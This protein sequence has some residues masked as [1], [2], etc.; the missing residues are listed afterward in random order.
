MNIYDT[1]SVVETYFQNLPTKEKIMALLVIPLLLGG[2]SFGYLTPQA[3]QLS[4]QS[5]LYA[6]Q[7]SLTHEKLTTQITLEKNQSPQSPLIDRYT[8]LQQEQITLTNTVSN[9]LYFYLANTTDPPSYLL[10]KVTANKLELVS[11]TEKKPSSIDPLLT[12]RSWE[13]KL[14]GEFNDITTFLRTLTSTH[15]RFIIN[16]LSIEK[17][18]VSLAVVCTL[19]FVG[20]HE[21]F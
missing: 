2:I 19:S 9:S 13:L 16:E 7:L 8:A 12:N 18:E 11:L 3:Q 15:P 14:V 6:K 5:L 17:K 21:N 4:Q 10:K 20:F 1:I